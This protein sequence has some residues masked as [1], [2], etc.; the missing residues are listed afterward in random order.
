MTSLVSFYSTLTV[1]DEFSTTKRYSNHSFLNVKN[2]NE[3]YFDVN[4]SVVG[5]F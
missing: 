2:G 1:V 3:D 4:E 5:L